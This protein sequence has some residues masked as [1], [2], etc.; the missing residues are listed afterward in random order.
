MWRVIRRKWGPVHSKLHHGC[1]LPWAFGWW[2]CAVCSFKFEAHPPLSLQFQV[3]S[4]MLNSSYLVFIVLIAYSQQISLFTKPPWSTHNCFC[5]SKKKLSVWGSTH[6]LDVISTH[7][8]SVQK[9]VD[10]VRLKL[11]TF[12]LE[13]EALPTRPHKNCPVPVEHRLNG[14]LEVTTMRGWLRPN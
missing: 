3:C 2:W 11:T 4:I 1:T 5:S 10:F 13:Q 6:N 7:A 14:H 9:K 12:M 8:I